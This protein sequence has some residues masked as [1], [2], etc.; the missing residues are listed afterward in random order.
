MEEIARVVSSSVGIEFEKVLKGFDVPKESFGDL[1]LVL[2]RA[3]IDP[4][5]GEE[6]RKAVEGCSYV[7]KSEL[8][9]IYLNMWFDR[10]RFVEKV[11]RSFVEAG[12]SYGVV[13]F[14]SRRIVVE[15]VSAN[16]VHP[17]HVG[18]ARNAALGQALANMLEAAGHVVQRRFYINDV[19]RQVAILV[20]GIKLL[21]ELE[22]PHGWKPDHWLGMVYAATNILMELKK[23]REELSQVVSDERRKELI[24]RMD[25]LLADLA[26]IREAL[27]DAVDKLIDAMDRVDPEREV[28]EIARKYEAG[29]P[30]VKDFV[31]KVVELCIQGFKQTLDRFGARFDV[32]DWE[33]DL[34][35]SSEVSKIVEQLSRSPYRTL[36]KGVPAIDFSTLLKDPNIREKLR[37]PKGLEV[38]PLILMRSDETTLYTVR[39]IAYTLKKFRDFNADTVINVIAS[40]QLLPQAQL[41]L[42]LYVLGYRKEAENLIHYS[43]EMVQLSGFRMSSRRG[44]IVTLDEVLDEAK[45]RAY[46]ELEKRGNPN[47]EIAERIGVAAVKFALVS[48]SPNRPVRFSWENVLNFERNSAPY[49]LYT[50]ART[51][52]ILRKAEELGIATEPR[53]LLEIY[54]PSFANDNARRW[55]LVKMIAELP[56]TF[57][58]AVENLDPSMLAIYALK[59]ADEFNSWYD[60]DPVI[61]ESNE[62]VRAS[63]LLLV[64]AVSHCLA[65]TLRILGIEPLERM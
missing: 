31:R 56:E 64:H 7:A 11:F 36:Y 33:S 9:G 41:R 25:K 18:A 39:D 48:V 53:K 43:Y 60:E 61:R 34:V 37:I 58:R 21:G 38:P 3:G 59:L 23:V 17:L 14:P 62:G 22:P 52:G 6:V 50:Y 24:D 16:P 35:W 13:R 47:E 12:N 42:A 8:V 29:D 2:P 57:V 20:L 4:S 1:T 28:V 55:R 15:Y 26:R 63:K 27:P 30:E 44:R 5:K 49:L 54:D 45:T 19:G 32:W 40:E 65:T 51:R 10:A 46:A